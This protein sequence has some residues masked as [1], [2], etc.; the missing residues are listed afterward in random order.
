VASRVEDNEKHTRQN[1][2]DQNCDAQFSHE[3]KC[4]LTF[5]L[6]HRR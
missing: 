3:V 6:S 1:R 2:G 4:G 5:K